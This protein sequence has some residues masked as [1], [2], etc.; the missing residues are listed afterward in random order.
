MIDL[1]DLP[2]LYYNINFQ[3]APIDANA[4][5]VTCQAGYP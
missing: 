4:F 2:D 1:C 3:K 5:H